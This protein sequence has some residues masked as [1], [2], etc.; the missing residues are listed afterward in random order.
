MRI[1]QLACIFF[2]HGSRHYD[3]WMTPILWLIAS[4]R[5]KAC[6]SELLHRHLN[7]ITLY[8]RFGHMTNRLVKVLS[9]ILDVLLF[10]FNMPC[11]SYIID[12]V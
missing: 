9:I 12:D 2:K 3:L 11:E 8:T 10:I 1:K 5:K 4:V 6:H 7:K